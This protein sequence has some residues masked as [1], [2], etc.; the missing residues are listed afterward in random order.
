[1]E[2][3]AG[4]WSGGTTSR[5][6]PF[7]TST[8]PALIPRGVT[9]RRERKALR[10]MFL[11]RLSCWAT[12]GYRNRLQLPRRLRRAS[13][14]RPIPGALHH[15]GEFVELTPCHRYASLNRDLDLAAFSTGS[16]FPGASRA[17]KSPGTR[18]EEAAAWACGARRTDASALRK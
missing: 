14:P 12:E 18:R 13:A 16:S 11:A 4:S 10:L 1:M 9:I 2:F 3:C 17:K 15:L 5:I 7:C 8:A 6:S